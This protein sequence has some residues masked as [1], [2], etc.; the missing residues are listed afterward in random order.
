[1]RMSWSRKELND[2]LGTIMRGIHDRCDEHGEETGG[3]VNDLKGANVSGFKKVADTL[4]AYG[5]A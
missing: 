1:M 4:I 2:H 5:A 3:H